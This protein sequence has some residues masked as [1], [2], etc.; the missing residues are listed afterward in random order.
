MNLIAKTC[1]A[2]GFCL[3]V[4]CSTATAEEELDVGDRQTIE[5]PLLRIERG[6]TNGKA[7]CSF[8]SKNGM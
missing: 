6:Q 2:L 1:T 5:T 3:F 8:N 7:K 4:F